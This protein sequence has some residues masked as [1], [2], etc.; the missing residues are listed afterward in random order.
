VRPM[1]VA[2]YA[3]RWPMSHREGRGDETLRLYIYGIRRF[4]DRFGERRLDQLW[5]LEC[6]VWAHGARTLDVSSARAMLNDAR[7]DGLVAQNP[8]PWLR[9]DRSG[10][11]R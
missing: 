1:T 4:V 3:S 11:R 10:R 8:I 9:P 6:L 2:E 5:L 7:R